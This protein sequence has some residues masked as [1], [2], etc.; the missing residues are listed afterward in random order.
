MRDIEQN[1]TYTHAKILSAT[2]N[3]GARTHVKDQALY[4]HREQNVVIRHNGAMA[5]II[6]TFESSTSVITEE[7]ILR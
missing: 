5:G 6:Y 1:R 7:Y 4:A 3:C 2:S